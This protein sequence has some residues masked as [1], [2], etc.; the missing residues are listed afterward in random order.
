MKKVNIIGAGTAGLAA[1]IRLASAGYDVTI[2]EKNEKIGGRMYQFD[3]EGYKFDVGP[4]I[5][6]MKDI[7]EDVFRSSGVDPKDYISFERLDPMFRLVFPDKSVLNGTSDLV[8][9]TEEHERFSEKDT[10]GYLAYLADVYKRYVIAKNHFIEKSFRKKTDFYNPATLYQALKLRTFSNAYDSIGSFVKN[11]KLRQALAFQTLYI[12]VSPFSGPSI[13]TIIPMIE[14]LYG[15][16]YI[17]GGMYAMA[18]AMERRFLELGGKIKLNQS[19]EEILIDNKKQAYGIRVNGENHLS[20]I[21]LSN[22]DFPY[23]MNNLVKEKRNKGKYT[24]KKIDKMSY[25]SSSLMIYLGMD[26]KYDVSVHNIYFTD[27]FKKNITQLFTDTKPT[28]PSFYVYS[29]SQI[30]QDMAPE[31]KD[32]LYILV[33]VPNLHHTEQSWDNKATQVYVDK[34][35]DLMTTYDE[36]KD[37]KEHIK[38]KKVFT[39]LDFKDTFNLAQGAT[40]GLRPTLLQSNYFRPQTKSRYVKGLYFAGSSNHPGAGVPIVLTSAKLAVSDILKDDSHDT[41]KK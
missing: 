31:G 19:V 37:V 22:A 30:D 28:Y 17:K 6:M 13:Y 3:L 9:M 32:I 18:K 8:A 12:G 21:V 39:P 2:F 14:L 24:P 20:D 4:T 5:V 40:F 26:K 1:G 23:A 33:P 27:D 34:I 16:F 10:Q 38:V 41:N 25:S 29:P 35:L 11:E 15:V 36:F 7:Y